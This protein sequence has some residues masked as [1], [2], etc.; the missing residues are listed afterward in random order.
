[1]LSADRSM[2][3]R[4]GQ[5]LPLVLGSITEGRSAVR[6]L[7]LND[8]LGYA[9]GVIHGATTYFLQT[10]P[11]LHRSS[12]V[13]LTVCFLRGP[14]PAAD[15]LRR[16]G[17][18]PIFL[19]RRKRDPRVVRDLVRLVR[20][21]NIEVIHAAGIKGMLGALICARI[22]GV[23]CIIHFHDM[24]RIGLFMRRLLG[25]RG[26]QADAAIGVSDAVC[27]YAAQVIAL[28]SERIYL[29]NNPLALE[30]YRRH[31][32]ECAA[33]RRSLNI[34]LNA[35]VMLMS[36][37]FFPVKQQRVAISAMPL[38][39]KKAPDAQLL[40]AGDGP[41]RRACERLAEQLRVSEC[42]RF[43]GQRNG[44]ADLLQI[45]DV[46][47]MPSASE[48]LPYSA[49]EAMA[50]GCPVVGYDVGGMS[51]AVIDGITGFLV[52]PGDFDALVARLAEVLSDEAVHRRLS[53]G[54]RCRAKAFDPEQHT[55]A[56]T[57][58]YHQFVRVPPFDRSDPSPEELSTGSERHSATAPA[59][60]SL[61]AEQP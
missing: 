34:D 41:Q 24:K 44:V 17:V 43:L 10:L 52:P 8:H 19:S 18:A 27:R 5:R 35:P 46:V 12:K 45:A 31:P 60:Q 23:R 42:V 53:A 4:N 50:A 59:V 1:M 58:L 3:G 9:G 2:P 25:F 39:R 36:G 29:L 26:F 57:A 32:E 20:E 47:V 51:E 61:S 56:L 15:T 40:L 28:P 38:L 54:A 6:V 14:H 7:V 49:L 48:G 21:R 33:V 11:G 16:Q 13:D 37:R 55:K 22:T 30:P